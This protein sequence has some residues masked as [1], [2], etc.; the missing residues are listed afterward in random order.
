MKLKII[1]L[2][3][4]SVGINA[5]SIYATT[6]TPSKNSM[7]TLTDQ[8]FKNNIQNQQSAGGSSLYQGRDNSSS[9]YQ[10][11]SGSALTAKP[12]AKSAKSSGT[13]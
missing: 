6:Q 5:S 11:G 8:R 2:L 12:T 9:L 13:H 4:L 3:I 1:L 10:G 7:S